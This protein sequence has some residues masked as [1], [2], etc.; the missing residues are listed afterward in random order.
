MR[1]ALVGRA[2]G[3]DEQHLIQARTAAGGLGRG[4]VAVV[5]GV[6]SAPEKSYPHPRPTTA[7]LPG[8]LCPP[9]IAGVKASARLRSP[10]SGGLDP[11]GGLCSAQPCPPS[12]ALAAALPACGR[13]VPTPVLPRFAASEV[14]VIPVG[15][16]IRLCRSAPCRPAPPLPPPAPG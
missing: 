4:E 3:G 8:G 12:A 13:G 11:C 15:T 14:E 7:T 16:R 1:P 10:A 9:D 2:T 5:N 6:K